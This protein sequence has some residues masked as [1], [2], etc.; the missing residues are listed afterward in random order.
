MMDYVC[1]LAGLEAAIVIPMMPREFQA[2]IEPVTHSSP[3][4]M[5]SA[6][7]ALPA[8]VLIKWFVAD[9]FPNVVHAQLL[10]HQL[11]LLRTSGCM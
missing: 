6:R 10:H 3:A 9:L 8:G 4:A 2:T 1:I 7:K 5:H 11:Q